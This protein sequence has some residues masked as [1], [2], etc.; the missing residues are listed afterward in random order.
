[1]PEQLKETWNGQLE[2]INGDLSTEIWCENREKYGERADIIG[3]NGKTNWKKISRNQS[4]AVI[5]HRNTFFAGYLRLAMEPAKTM[6]RNHPKGTEVVLQY[7]FKDMVNGFHSMY[8]Y[9]YI[10]IYTYIYI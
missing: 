9:I 7:I 6:G 3:E 2:E 8:I 1:M 5:N 4:F 10:Y